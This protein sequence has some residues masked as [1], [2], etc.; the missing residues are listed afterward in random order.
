MCPSVGS[1]LFF[2]SLPESTGNKEIL[3]LTPNVSKYGL[4]NASDFLW[5]HSASIIFTTP[6]RS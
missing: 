5:K 6:K 1:P 2:S 3:E 4:V